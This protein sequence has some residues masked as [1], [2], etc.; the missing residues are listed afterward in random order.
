MN[1]HLCFDVGGTNIKAGILTEEG[2]LLGNINI[3][4]SKGDKSADDILDHFTCLID[5]MLSNDRK[6]KDLI[7]Q[8]IHLAF[9]G[10]FDYE[11]GI[12]YMQGLDKY[13]ALYGIDI[14]EEL[15][16]RLEQ[17]GI[18]D[19]NIYFCNDVE[20]FALGEDHFGVGKTVRRNKCA[21]DKMR[22]MFI[23]IGTGCGSAFL[24]D[25]RA[26][27]EAE[28]GVPTEGWVYYLPFRDGIIDDYISKRGLQNIAKTILGEAYDGKQLS[29]LAEE[30]EAA[31]RV[32]EQ[33][34]QDLL[35]AFGEMIEAFHPDYFV[36][37]GAVT[38]SS[39]YFIEPLVNYCEKKGIVVH[40]SD[41]TSLSA[42]RGLI[43]NMSEKEKKNGTYN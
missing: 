40:I 27:K 15:Q 43:W 21:N 36:L 4:E 12:S 6:E 33:F 34:G 32:F 13:E 10:P 37:G 41:E 26:V 38:K 35:E 17:I 29:Q 5:Q 28:K 3:I 2:E 24:K 31:R 16:K 20:A 8:G 1:V 18:L 25:G 42:M 30:E 7:V 23:C 14:R 11:N 19:S 9:P 39:G 22:G